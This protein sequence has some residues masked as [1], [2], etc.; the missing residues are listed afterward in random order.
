MFIV[1]DVVKL[2]VPAIIAFCIGIIIAF[3]LSHYLYKYKLWKKKAGKVDFNGASTPIFNALHKDKEV[4][5]PRMGGIIVW[6]SPILTI[7]LLSLIARF[8]P[9]TATVKLELLSRNQTWLPLFTLIAGGLVGIFDD[10]FEIRNYKGFGSGGLS[11]SKRLFIVGLI[12]LAG[13]LWFYQKLG[14]SSISIPDFLGGSLSLGIFFVPFF[15]A[16]TLALYSGGIIDG[17]DGLAGGIFAAMFSAYA[18]IAFGQFQINLAAFCLAVVGAI[19]AFLWFNIPPARF[20][21]SETGSMALTVT[22]SVVAFLTDQIGEGKGILVLP[23]IALPLIATSLSVII[24]LLSKRFRAGQKVFLSAPLHHH[25][26]AIGWPSYKV[27]MRYWII[28]TVSAI[29]GI[30]VA[31]VR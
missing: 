16:V 15:I 21:M 28:G 1:S 12:G 4:G 13:G 18:V 19:L 17:L 11:L 26:E 31:L 7:I 29:T 6:L 10:I 23:I 20:Y 9:A 3:I 2:F 14:I 22:L 27:T 8:L 24:Q 5:T 30:I 25:F